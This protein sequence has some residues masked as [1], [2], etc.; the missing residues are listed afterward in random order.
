[1][2]P[3]VPVIVPQNAYISYLRALRF[4]DLVQGTGAGEYASQLLK[5]CC[6]SYAKGLAHCKGPQDRLLIVRYACFVPVMA[7]NKPVF[8]AGSRFL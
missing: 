8:L 4:G 7:I 6:A 2:I 1:M 5:A 3:L